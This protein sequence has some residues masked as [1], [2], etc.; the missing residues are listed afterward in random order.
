LSKATTRRLFSSLALLTLVIPMLGAGPHGKALGI[1]RRLPAPCSPLV[2]A[3]RGASGYRPE[4]TLAA[5]ELAID[6]GADY[7]EP[8]LVMTADG[9]LIARHDNILD[10][11]TDVASR[12][13]FASKRTTKTLDGATITGWFSEDFTLAEIKRL[14][15][16]ER[17]PDVRPANA[18]F[19]GRFQIPTLAE[20]IRLVHTKERALRRRIGLYIETKHPTHFA[21]QGLDLNAA[22][23]RT[24][25][26]FGYR[27]ARDP[28]FIQSFEVANLQALARRTTLRRVQLLGFGV[29][30]DVQLAGGTTTY[31]DMATPTGL[32]RIRRYADGIGPD[33][34]QVI[35]RDPTNEL[36]LA[37]ATSLTHDAHAAG[38]LVHPY[39]FRAEN[40]FLPSNF[41][42]GAEP[43]DLGDVAGE[44][45]VFLEAGVD[46]FFTDHPDL[47]GA[48]KPPCSRRAGVEDNSG[49]KRSAPS[50]P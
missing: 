14:R 36:H 37:N 18:T 48:T 22:L 17:I 49:G 39:T 13:E 9:A 40:R 10:L 28:V 7:V 29:P 24:L 25:H 27:S 30:W 12:P 5:Y 3:H 43:N 35:P 38:L 4:H 31:A 16:V 6:M 45:A 21:T 19:D 33:R 15:A 11:T 50:L 20:I 2:I 42:A 44:I 46:G 41:R 8:D 34:S 1:R 23:V 32:A 47:A 26:R